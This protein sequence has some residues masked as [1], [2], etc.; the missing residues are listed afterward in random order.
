MNNIPEKNNKVTGNEQADDLMKICEDDVFNL[1][2]NI[3]IARQKLDE[4]KMECE[5]ET[6][7][8]LLAFLSI[9]DS[10]K[11]RFDEFELKKKDLSEETLTW[12]S[13]FSITYKKL[14][15]TIK[16]CGLTTVEIVPGDIFNAELHNA[17]EVI[18]DSGKKNGTII[19]EVYRGYCWKGKVLRPSDV[20][21][22]RN[23]KIAH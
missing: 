15:N 4:S 19:Q 1:V 6:R 13:K 18:E 3:G 10:F 23:S 12:I 21:I 20:I 9:A 11:S 5:G 17:V 8:I 14:L 2:K 16:E 7:K 22:S